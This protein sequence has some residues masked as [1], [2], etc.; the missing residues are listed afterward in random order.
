MSVAERIGNLKVSASTGENVILESLWREKPVILLDD[1]FSELDDHHQ[2]SL[3][4]SLSE[5][6]VFIS[7]THI[8]QELYGARVWE[9]GS[10]RVMS[11]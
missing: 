3:L 11:H 5:H 10:E 1:V 6:Q 4:R 9:V 2:T 8:P 7:T